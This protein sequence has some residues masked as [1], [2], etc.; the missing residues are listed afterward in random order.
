MTTTQNIPD[1]GPRP[2]PCWTVLKDDGE[3]TGY[4]GAEFHFETR[5]KAEADARTYGTIKVTVTQV[6]GKVCC[7]TA[8]LLCGEQFVY[9]GDDDE[10]H[11]ADEAHLLSCADVQGNLVIPGKG[12]TC[13]PTADCET[14]T[15]ARTARKQELALRDTHPDVFTRGLT[16]GW[17]EDIA[18][19]TEIDWP[20]RRRDSLMPFR[21]EDGRPVNPVN[22]HLPYGR[23]ELGHWGEKANA[24]AIVFARV[25]S[26]RYVLMGERDD[27]HGWAFPGGGRDGVETPT[28]NAL[29]E[30]REETRLVIDPVKRARQITVHTVRHVADPRESREAWMVTVPVVIDL[31]EVV[32]LPTVAGSDDLVRAEWFPCDTAYRVTNRITELGGKLFKSHER[33]LTD[34]VYGRLS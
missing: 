11:F 17:A 12:L 27:G 22:P 10:V 14:C 20:A 31:G 6:P 18:D 13:D 4:L 2:E 30:L 23:G 19:P 25:G 26:R 29:R 9:Q 28:A 21:I 32:Q 7:W 1:V 24:D 3:G 8:T 5:E 34:A 16:E 15:P 33:M